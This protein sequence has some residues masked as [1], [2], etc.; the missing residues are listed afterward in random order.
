M[1]LSVVDLQKVESENS[2]HRKA[3]GVDIIIAH[4]QLGDI[5]TLRVEDVSLPILW[6]PQL[7]VVFRVFNVKCGSTIE[8]FEYKKKMS[9]LV[10]FRRLLAFRLVVPFG[11]RDI[12]PLFI[13]V[14]VDF[15]K[16][17]KNQ[18]FV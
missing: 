12:E 3:V 8:S 18:G 5:A 17:A 15:L 10:Y 6:R 14:Y 9:W 2:N 7:H 13:A 11:I 1:V 16:A 4:H